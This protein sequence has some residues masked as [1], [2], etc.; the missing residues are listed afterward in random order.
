[1]KVLKSESAQVLRY[2]CE[3]VIL[4]LILLSDLRICVSGSKRELWPM[5][6]MAHCRNAV[7]MDFAIKCSGLLFR[8]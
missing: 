7:I 5:R 8:R 1:M 6:F 4:C 3:G 2:E